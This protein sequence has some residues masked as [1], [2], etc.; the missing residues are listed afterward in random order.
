MTCLREHKRILEDPVIKLMSFDSKTSHYPTDN[1]VPL[2]IKFKYQE[3]HSHYY[4]EKAQ[5]KRETD[6][7]EPV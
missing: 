6:V 2:L 4:N 1:L 5:R 3:K 7:S